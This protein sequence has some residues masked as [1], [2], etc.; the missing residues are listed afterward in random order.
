MVASAIF[1]LCAFSLLIG[2]IVTS[3]FLYVKLDFFALETIWTYLKSR[4]HQ[5]F[6]FPNPNVEISIGNLARRVSPEVAL[7]YIAEDIFYIRKVVRNAF[8][9]GG[10]S[11]IGSAL[12]IAYY[13]FG[14]GR[15]KMADEHLRGA[16]EV[17]G[18]EL[19]KLM[20]A[21]ND[22]S[23]YDIAG[24]PIRSKAETL[25]T[26]IAGSQGTGKSQAFFPLMR[27]VRARGK[28]AI[29]Y[30]P[31]GEYIQEF[32]REGKDILLNPLD[33]R[34]PCWNVWGEIEQE[35]HFDNLANA[36]IPSP[37]DSQTDPF[38][39]L[40]GRHLLRD[41]Y[42]VLGREGK[43]TNR[44]LYNLIA[45]SNLETLHEA[46]QG[47]SGATYV[48]PVT[49][50]TGMSLKMTVQNQLESF[51]FL[52][53]DGPEFSI[54]KW[55]QDEDSDSWIFIGARESQREV[56]K[57]VMSL[58]IDVAIKAV[59]DLEPIH[60]ER[61]WG[62]LDELPTLQRLDV[63]KLAV[64]NTR[65][66]GLCLAIGMQDFSQMYEIYGD[67]LAKAIIS[68]CQTKLLLRVTDGA[69][70]KLLSE[71]IGESE[72]DEKEETQSLGLTANRDGVSVYA[73]RNRRDVLL[74]S[75]FRLL[76]DMTGYLLVPGDY[77]VAKVEYK[78]VK[79]P[80]NTL[81]FIERRGFGISFDSLL[82][83]TGGGTP[84]ESVFPIMESHGKVKK[85]HVVTPMIGAK[86]T[87][88]SNVPCDAP[89]TCEKSASMPMDAV[90]ESHTDCDGL[91]QVRRSGEDDSKSL[92]NLF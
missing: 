12:C 40:A 28:R 35:Y 58:W 11:F 78:Y 14:F 6:T 69:S 59:L 29:V 26:I 57:P 46:L 4:A 16:E 2:I 8:I 76:P 70:A 20:N 71:C 7:A 38:W 55:I 89:L 3:F 79:S 41:A 75:Q 91:S 84:Q 65:K 88:G 5:I 82:P 92:A 21:R 60:R 47:T 23:P 15:R 67:A 66:F 53:D 10:L 85:E 52:R 50:R 54:R 80:K 24:V 19:K 62:F 31:S 73:R 61:I 86:S 87:M 18:Q 42:R 13:W 90:D 1:V 44:D 83:H 33:E 9:V 68:G 27:Q 51:R 17:S 25:H 39:S 43:R 37:S 34:S 64:T 81:P 45:R 22:C 48:D 56:L 72:V 30:C 63:L 74:P 49:E 36:L 32:F 77:P